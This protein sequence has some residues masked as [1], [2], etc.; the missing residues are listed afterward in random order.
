[1]TLLVSNAR[2]TGAPLAKGSKSA[3]E[4]APSAAKRLIVE[5]QKK[6]RK[7][8][9]LP[10]LV[11]RPVGEAMR[12]ADRA[13][14]AR[15]AGDPKNAALLDKLAERWATAGTAVL[16]A[17]LSER[18][19]KRQATR[20]SALTTKLKRAEALLHEQQAR[21][22]RLRA[23]LKRLQAKTATR[24]ATTAGAEKRRIDKS[25][26]KST[27]RPPKKGTP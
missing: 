4:L 9:L 10:E 7:Q 8:K 12:A 18:A 24:K 15:D 22:G 21:L 13:T 17:I 25:G 26:T 11:R 5:L 19:A 14:G 20:L 27:E 1:M 3:S 23:E 6:V 16:R 2:A